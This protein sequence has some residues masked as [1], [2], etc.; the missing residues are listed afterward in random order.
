MINS[1]KTIGVFGCQF[2]SRYR[3]SL[4][5]VFNDAAQ[6]LRVNLVF[7]NFLGKI[8]DRNAEYGEYELDLIKYIDLDQF[9]GIIFD[10]EANNLPGMADAVIEKLRTARCPV[11]SISTYVEGFCNTIFEDSYGMRLII[12]HMLE[13]VKHKIEIL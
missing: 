10:G 5:K 6:E 12:E 13:K 7:V 2:S 1:L 4:P 9:D 11:V 3:M 8:G